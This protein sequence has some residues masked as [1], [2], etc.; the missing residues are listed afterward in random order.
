MKERLINADFMLIAG[1]QLSEIPRPGDASFHLPLPFLPVLRRRFLSIRLVRADQVDASFLQPV[2]ADQNRQPGHRSVAW[3]WF[4]VVPGARNL[5]ALQRR[6]D[7][8]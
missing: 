7:Q 6:F 3:A 4:A 2:A 1:H 8:R 5:H